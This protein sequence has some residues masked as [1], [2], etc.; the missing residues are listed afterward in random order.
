MAL[1]GTK[2]KIVPAE[3]IYLLGVVGD[4]LKLTGITF[5][6]TTSRYKSMTTSNDAPM[7]KTFKLL[8]TP[9]FTINKGVEKTVAWLNLYH[10][11]LVK[12]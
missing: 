7:E 10:P 1:R 9:P 4:F 8:G 3:I 12:K 2:I 11:A 6:I 5:P